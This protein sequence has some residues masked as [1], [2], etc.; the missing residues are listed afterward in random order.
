M[1]QRARFLIFPAVRIDVRARGKTPSNRKHT[2]SGLCSQWPSFDGGHAS[3]VLLITP[4]AELLP[5][6]LDG[7]AEWEVV[8]TGAKTLPRNLVFPGR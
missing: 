1:E 5:A 2:G 6:H 7:V 4:R 3:T 8:G